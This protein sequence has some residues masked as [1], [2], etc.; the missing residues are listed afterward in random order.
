MRSIQ[1]Q[2]PARVKVGTEQNPPGITL[3][4]LAV[5]LAIVGL[6]AA[7]LAPAVQQARAAMRLVHCK[8]NLHQLG[9]AVLNYEATYR[10]LPRRLTNPL[11]GFLEQTA[12]ADLYAQRG[13]RAASVMQR[14]RIPLFRCPADPKSADIPGMNYGMNHGW[15]ISRRSNIHERQPP[16]RLRDITDG[17]S[18]SAC[19]SEMLI[20]DTN[21]KVTWNRF[22][23]LTF[24]NADESV[25]VLECRRTPATST[26]NIQN[27]TNHTWPL[28]NTQYYHSLTPNNQPCWCGPQ[29]TSGRWFT[30][31][32]TSLHAQGVNVLFFDGHVGFVGDSVD[33]DLWH[34]LGTWNGQDQVSGQF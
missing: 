11:L 15:G 28:V 24:L 7:V 8:G 13:L 3:V 18:S 2:T 29:G 21:L 32:A 12:L 4:E 25:A 26:P 10:V 1:R 16:A 5:S 19:A 14:T 17:V 6:L 30:R 23:P 27:G 33:A 31:T 34:H 22:M 9:V 20:S